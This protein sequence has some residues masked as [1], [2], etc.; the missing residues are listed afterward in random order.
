MDGITPNCGQQQG[1]QMSVEFTLSEV[2]A[3]YRARLPNLNQ[4]GAAWR[5]PCPIHNG[6]RDSF[7][8]DPTT[9]KACCHSECGAGWDILGLEQVYAGGD[10]KAAKAEVFRIIGRHEEPKPRGEESS[11]KSRIVAEYDYTD[12]A[13]ELLY[14]VIRFE[15]KGFRQ[16][17]PDGKGGWIWNLKGVEPVLYKLP[18]LFAAEAGPETIRLTVYIVEGERDVE[19]LEKWGLVATCNS[20]GAGKLAPGFRGLLRGQARRYPARPG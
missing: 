8:V 15:P 7:A 11:A 18:E 1:G 10:F 4:R 20:G 13:G 19:T 2:A 14:Q 17:R 5:C 16:R 12:P 3:Y 6:K 9:G